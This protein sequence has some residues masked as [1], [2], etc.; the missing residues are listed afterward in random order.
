MRQKKRSR[1]NQCADVNGGWRASLAQRFTGREKISRP[2]HRFQWE[3]V[4]FWPA[5]C[6]ERAKPIA[7]RFREYL[8]NALKTFLVRFW[9]FGRVKVRFLWI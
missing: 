7:H 9:L 5:R 6:L 3:N 4:P 1:G 2:V 8:F